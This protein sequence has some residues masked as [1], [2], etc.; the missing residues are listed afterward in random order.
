MENEINLS[1][2]QINLL[3]DSLLKNENSSQQELKRNLTK[4]Q[5]EKLQDIMSDP[6]KIRAVL[7]SPEAKKLLEMLRNKRE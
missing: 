5:S 6:Q 1:K 7:T 4:E 3:L 2:Q